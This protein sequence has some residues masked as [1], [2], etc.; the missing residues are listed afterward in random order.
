MQNQEKQKECVSAENQKQETKRKKKGKIAE[1][2]TLHQ[3][4]VGVKEIAQKMK[5]SERIVRNYIWRAK[6]PQKYKKLL[7]RYYEKKKQKI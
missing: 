2:H 7:A 3:K 1:A 6:N 4:G 5:L